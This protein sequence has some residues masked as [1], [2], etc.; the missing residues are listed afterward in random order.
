MDGVTKS[1]LGGWL[2]LVGIGVI[3]APFILSATFFPIFIPLFTDGTMETIT[4]S[5]NG[6]FHPLLGPLIYLEIVVNSA[7]IILH[8]YLIYLFFWKKKIFPNFYILA[9]LG[10]L[11]FLVIDAFLGKIVMPNDP[12]FD[13]ETTKNIIRSAVAAAIW[14]PYMRISKRVNATFVN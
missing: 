1:G 13:P 6:I 8:F 14:V 11:S 10:G 9:M 2:I 7:L 12:I 5:E 3:L 4:S